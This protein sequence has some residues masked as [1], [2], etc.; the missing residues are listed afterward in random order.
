MRA[1]LLTFA[2]GAA[3]AAIGCTSVSTVR[4]QPETVAVGPGL[5]PV[6]GIQANATS[7]YFLFIPLPGG[8]ELDN[9]V[10]RL[11]IV[12][13]KTLGADKIAGLEFEVTP[14][15]GVWALRKLLG[16][17]SASARGIA[18]QVVDAAPDLNADDGPEA[19]P[20]GAPGQQ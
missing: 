16:W 17:R 1:L 11:L 10:N 5:R 15:N 3:V 6:A 12:T 8:A 14:D 4:L 9:V 13:A 19:P 2:L 18:V 20:E 7:A